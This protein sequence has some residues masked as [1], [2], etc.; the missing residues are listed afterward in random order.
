MTLTLPSGSNARSSILVCWRTPGAPEASGEFD[1]RSRRSLGRNSE[2]IGRTVIAL[3]VAPAG[4]SAF[5]AGSFRRSRAASASSKGA[6]SR[7]SSVPES[8]SA[9]SA[10]SP[11]WIKMPNNSGVLAHSRLSPA[12]SRAAGE[13]LSGGG[14]ASSSAAARPEVVKIA[15]TIQR[16]E[17]VPG[18]RQSRRVTAVLRLSLSTIRGGFSQ[19]RPARPRRGRAGFRGS[20]P[21]AGPGAASGSRRTTRVQ[22]SLTIVPGR[23][24][25][26][27][28]GASVRVRS[29]RTRPSRGGRPPRPRRAGFGPGRR[30]RTP[31]GR[32]AGGRP[33]GRPRSATAVRL[34]WK[35]AGRERRSRSSVSTGKW[36]TTWP[37]RT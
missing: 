27:Y 14:A 33:G 9:L 12:T 13:P 6:C 31:A 23:E 32:R 22:S 18:G 25:P 37:S 20:S 19:R 17:A 35:M 26:R 7:R 10:G 29:P 2:R 30:W 15:A 11:P 36:S 8:R 34:D 16:S 4:S 5:Q 24:G 21:L 3:A 28:R 1:T